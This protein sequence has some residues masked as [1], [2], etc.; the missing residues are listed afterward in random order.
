MRGAELAKGEGGGVQRIGFS[1][2]E[3]KHWELHV[4]KA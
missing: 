4:R 2:N 3:T 1:P